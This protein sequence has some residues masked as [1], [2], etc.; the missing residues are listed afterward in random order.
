M[1]EQQDRAELPPDRVAVVWRRLKD[2]RIA[3]WTVGYVAIAYGIQ[4][5][6]T[7]TAD[8]YDWPHVIT[9]F[10][11]TLLALGLPIAMT[12]AWYHGERAG[13]RISAGE[14]SII[15]VLLVIASLLFYGFVRPASDVA[16]TRPE[17]I[18][19]TSRPAT[20]VS[21]AVLPFLNLSGDASQEFF[22]DGMTEEI[23][24]ALAKV[25]NMRVVGRTS[26]F[27]FK[28]AGKD[29]RAIGQALSATHLI[30]GSV[31]KDGN[32]VRITAQLVKADD[33]THLWTESYDR[34]L[35]GIFAV[36]EDV[37][38]A[39]AASL[40]VP[41]G[42][43][44]GE[45]LVSNRTGDTAS[46]EDYLRARA[47]FRLRGLKPLTDAAALLEQV[48]ARD[49]AYAPAWALLSVSYGV[50]PN[51]H[52][53]WFSGDIVELRRV[54]DTSLPR[55]E[56]AGR[57]AIELDATLADGYEGLALA[58]ERR[59]KL[60]EAEELY[61]KALT[62]DPNHPDTM[63]QYSQVLAE[64][65]RFD[66]AFAM[67]RRVQAIEPL[68]P[69]Y[70]LV[71]AIFLWLQG[72]NRA[73]IALYRGLPSDFDL[74]KVFLSMTYAS[75]GQYGDAADALSEIP[76]QTL[77]S[78]TTEAA[79]RLLR[80]APEAV[81]APESLPR[82]GALSFIYLYVG[83]TDRVL[84]NEEGDLEAG[85]MVPAH[86]LKFWHP[87]YAQVRRT[88]R[89]RKLMRNAGLVEYWRAKGWSP[90]CHPTTG[91]D[92]ECS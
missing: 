21:L 69:I 63:H 90:Q 91:D 45:T 87:S 78:G 67:R 55:A 84:E 20:G 46:Y 71:T 64:V 57:R 3:Q 82:L 85:Y 6:I 8:A 11:M 40:Q 15:S 89:F 73:A 37:A 56:V 18:A 19:G 31:R 77:A 65:G 42:L 79:M 49:P 25:P 75:V 43:K 24:S 76:A 81:Q 74:G 33:G 35:K 61:R 9:R 38:R 70:N 58:R 22:S 53:A 39:I 4:H 48:V 14:L 23:T 7:L 16:T 47:L 72:Q 62:I 59:G 66:E 2:H 5:G 88:E 50:L 28:G 13:R 52:P 17:T 83:A 36:Q 26:A 12:L 60:L 41:L 30:E 51:Y 1:S 92:F 32:Q 86:I 80:R 34:E 27:Q 29:L 54:T 68:V 10:S 44:K